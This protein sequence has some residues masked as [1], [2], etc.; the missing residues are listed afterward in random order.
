MLQSNRER[1][2]TL[3][4]MTKYSKKFQ[5]NF[6][7]HESI[8]DQVSIHFF[9]LGIEPVSLGPEM[10]NIASKPTTQP[11]LELTFSATLFCSQC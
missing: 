11:R 3:T 6:S 10:I 7:E 2:L 1:R 9:S 5:L 4:E 8:P